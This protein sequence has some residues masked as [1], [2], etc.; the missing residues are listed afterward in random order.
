MG[1]GLPKPRPPN[2]G[3]TGDR[4]SRAGPGCAHSKIA[5]RTIAFSHLR[6]GLTAV[7]WGTITAHRSVSGRFFKARLEVGGARPR[8]PRRQLGVGAK[9]PGRREAMWEPRA[10]NQ[11]LE[12]CARF[13]TL[14]QKVGETDPL[15]HLDNRNV[16]FDKSRWRACPADVPARRPFLAPDWS[17]LWVTWLPMPYR[18]RRRWSETAPGC[19]SPRIRASSLPS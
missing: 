16:S 7:A 19:P 15:E 8:K 2:D 9:A 17:A 1:R 12:I 6:R 18:R 3:C 5:S 10:Q 11:T 13:P 4:G 14:R